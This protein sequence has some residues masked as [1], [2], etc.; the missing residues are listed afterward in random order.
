MYAGKSAKMA[1][2]SPEK[3]GI[4]PGWLWPACGLLVLLA[5]AVIPLVYQARTDALAPDDASLQRAATLID[6]AILPND[7]LAFYPAWSAHRPWMFAKVWQDKGFSFDGQPILGSPIDLWDADGKSRL[8][9]VTTH[10]Y[11]DR[12]LQTAALQGCRAQKR[13]EIG[14]G[15]AVVLC[16]LPKSVTA[17]DF[18]DKL[19]EAKQFVF[20][21]AAPRAT[22]QE[23]P[24]QAIANPMYNGG[25][26]ACGSQEWKN[27]WVSLHEV[28]DTRRP[29]IYVHPPFA[30]GVLRLEYSNLPAGMRIAGRFGN[31]LWAVRHGDEGSAVTLRVMAGEQMLYRK[32]IGPADFGW[33]PFAVPLPASAAGLPIAF[34]V[35][36]EKDAWREAVLDARLLAD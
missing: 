10:G 18:R 30:N 36:A 2:H 4:L 19:A 7:G 17:F 21:A 29:G 32:T 23:C 14:H 31:R 22:W 33:Y 9:I 24:W 25:L 26:H 35:S 13:S 15:T 6:K 12:L 5:S 16:E 1:G 3:A 27:T 20:A 8:W 34:E 28:G 11:A